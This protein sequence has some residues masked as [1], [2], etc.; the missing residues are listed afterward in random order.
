[1]FLYFLAFWTILFLKKN[2]EQKDKEVG[3]R[4][5]TQVLTPLNTCNMRRWVKASKARSQELKV[6]HVSGM[7]TKFRPSLAASQGVHLPE[8]GLRSKA[9]TQNRALQYGMSAI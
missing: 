5:H 2:N 7:D 4:E 1:M 8:A 3:E 9:G 6:S